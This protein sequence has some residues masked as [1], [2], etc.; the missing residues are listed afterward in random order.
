MANSKGKRRRFGAVRKL[1]SG[2]FQARYQGPDGLTRSA[3]ETFPSQTDAD[4]WLVRKEAEIIDGRW[5]NPDDKVLFGV[6][7]DAWFKERDYAATTRERNGSALRL[8]I[9]PTFAN[10]VLSEITTPQIRRWRAGLLESGVGEPTVVKAYQVLRAIMNTAVDDELIQRNPCR[11]KGAGA[12]KTAE[13]PFLEVSEVFRLADSVPPRF[14]VLILLAAFTGLRFG[15]LAALQRHDVDLERRT[16]AVRRALAE[17]RTDGIVVKTPKSAAGVRTVAFPAS[18]TAELTAHLAAYAEPGR[19]GSVFTGERGGQLR[20]NNFRRLWLRALKTTGLGDVHFHDLRH[21]GNTL[22]A[23]GGAT[24]RELMQRMGHSSVRA[25]LIYQHL[26][27]GRD[28][29]I[30]AHVDEQIRKVRPAESD[31]PSGT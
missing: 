22:A 15:E 18:L 31:E 3:P 20:R 10:V 26:V 4:R 29:V 24:T 6:Y 25:A 11:I 17:T 8:H 19:T 23:T 9:L 16:V 5:K 7:A 2:R 14:R 21:T 12:A 28:H 13:R 27:N 30:A 1:P